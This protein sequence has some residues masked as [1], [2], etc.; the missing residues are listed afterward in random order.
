MYMKFKISCSTHVVL[1]SEHVEE[2]ISTLR[3]TNVAFVNSIKTEP[4]T[5]RLKLLA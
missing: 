2:E 5:T 3:V 4:L 1:A